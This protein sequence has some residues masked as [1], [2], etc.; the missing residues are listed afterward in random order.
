MARQRELLA[1]ACTDFDCPNALHCFIP[2]PKMRREGHE[3]ECR[4]CGQDL[5]DWARLRKL[6]K[7]DI[8]FVIESLKNEWIRARFWAE[9]PNRWA[10]NYALRK[11]RTALIGGV[12]HFLEANVGR[13]RDAYDGR[14]VPMP[15]KTPE[16]MNPYRYA[17]HATGTC[18][19]RCIEAWYGIPPERS[20]SPSE[21]DFFVA[22][23]EVHI[24][25]FYPS[26]P[27]NPQRVPGIPHDHDHH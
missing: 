27:G 7:L 21:L 1:I 4:G 2:T 3:G 13:P 10:V 9:I 24:K 5:I 22:L 8:P 12:A 25:R 6:S 20:L 11:G 23:V 18:C 17:Q 14:R 26:L 15:E 19:R 16:K